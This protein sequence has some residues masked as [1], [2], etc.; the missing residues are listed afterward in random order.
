[1]WP[2]LATKC[3]L[4]YIKGAVSTIFPIHLRRGKGPFT[5]VIV[6]V[7]THNRK[8]EMKL[9]RQVNSKQE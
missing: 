3:R 1:M 2:K 9:L 7:D 4:I 8:T 6:H 5:K